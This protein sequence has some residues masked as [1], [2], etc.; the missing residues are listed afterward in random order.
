LPAI[1]VAPPPP[2]APTPSP[3]APDAPAAADERGDTSGNT[4][5]ENSNDITDGSHQAPSEIDPQTW[6]WNWSWNCDQSTLAAPP[7]APAGSTVWIWNWQWSCA[8]APGPAPDIPAACIQ[9]NVALSIR[10]ASPGDDGAVTQSNEVISA[11]TAYNTAALAQN[12]SELAA[13]PPQPQPVT[14]DVPR[15]PVPPLPPI[16]P[17]PVVGAPSLPAMAAGGPGRSLAAVAPLRLAA[18]GGGTAGVSV[19][20]ETHRS[21]VQRRGGGSSR[22]IVRVEAHTSSSVIL[23]QQ[24]RW[25]RSSKAAAKRQS[26]QGRARPARPATRMPSA[27]RAP[28]APAATA[29]VGAA[30]HDGGS[31]VLTAAIVAALV[32][33]ALGLLSIVVSSSPPARRRLSDDRRARPG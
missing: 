14:V 19:V 27:P 11:V 10:I 7:R 33:L 2:P 8:G 9:C 15:P 5:E 20:A 13:A 28:S 1:P 3:P 26:G 17:P 25:T 16:P 21:V 6:V 24:M 23:R 12:I 4:A 31:S 18:P 22:T 29:S 30:A 32:L